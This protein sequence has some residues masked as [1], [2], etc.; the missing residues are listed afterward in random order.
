[1]CLDYILKTKVM[2]CFLLIF[3]KSFSK[4]CHAKYIIMQYSLGEF[5][6]LCFRLRFIFEKI[7]FK[8][9]LKH[10]YELYC[11]NNLKLTKQ[12]IWKCFQN[13]LWS[14]KNLYKIFVKFF[15]KTF[16]GKYFYKIKCVGIDGAKIRMRC[17]T[18]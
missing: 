12:I 7:V 13:N 8:I 2:K 6:Y 3:H 14:F 16:T 17:K 11:V 4:S 1:M 9:F 18:L 15:Y 5:L 10:D